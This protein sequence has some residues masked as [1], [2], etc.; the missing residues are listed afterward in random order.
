MALIASVTGA[1]GGTTTGAGGA[2][3]GIT[4]GAAAAGAGIG[5]YPFKIASASSWLLACIAASIAICDAFSLICYSVYAT[6]TGAYGTTGVTG[7][8][9]ATGY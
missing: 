7:A 1:I 6:A 2:I 5:I 4:I 9:G 8:T 3:G